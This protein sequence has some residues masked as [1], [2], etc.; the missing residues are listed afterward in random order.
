MRGGGVYVRGGGEGRREL[1]FT[2][3]GVNPTIARFK[4]P[5]IR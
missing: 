5:D 4:N 2:P 1:N 3:D